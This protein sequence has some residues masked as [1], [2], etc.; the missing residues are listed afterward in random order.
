MKIETKLKNYTRCNGCPACY[1]D[2]PCDYWCTLGYRDCWCES[3]KNPKIK[4]PKAC[5]E[6]YGK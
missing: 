5:I 2:P 3:G 4:R 1:F 6:D